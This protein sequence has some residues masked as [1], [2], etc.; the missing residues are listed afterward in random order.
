MHYTQYQ[1]KDFT[2]VRVHVD[3]YAVG[4]PITHTLH[5][6]QERTNTQRYPDRTLKKHA[7]ISRFSRNTTTKT[8]SRKRCHGHEIHVGYLPT[9]E[10]RILRLQASRTTKQ[11]PAER[12]R[13]LYPPTILWTLS[14]SYFIVPNNTTWKVYTADPGSPRPYTTPVSGEGV[15]HLATPGERLP[16]NPA[17]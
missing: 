12:K 8:L 10:N 3:E 4:R 9:F 13:K 6:A 14:L 7:K 1:K 5:T 17:E 16:A 2:S 15:P 11:T